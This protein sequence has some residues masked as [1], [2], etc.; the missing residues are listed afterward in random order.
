MD[1]WKKL[2]FELLEGSIRRIGCVRDMQALRNKK[3]YCCLCEGRVHVGVTGCRLTLECDNCKQWLECRTTCVQGKEYDVELE[4]I[5]SSVEG[6]ELDKLINVLVGI[7]GEGGFE[8]K[9]VEQ[10]NTLSPF[11][12]CF[13]PGVSLLRQVTMI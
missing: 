13:T 3:G 1:A 8:F 5:E 11:S 10:C 4:L 6:D 9:G 12:Q 2:K 7:F